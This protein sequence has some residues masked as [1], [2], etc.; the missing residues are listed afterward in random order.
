M[1]PQRPGTGVFLLESEGDFPVGWSTTE[2]TS[3]ALA[4]KVS[5]KLTSYNISWNGLDAHHQLAYHRLQRDRAGAKGPSYTCFRVWCSKPHL[6]RT[7][8]VL[9]PQAVKRSG[10][11]HINGTYVVDTAER[12][13]ARLRLQVQVV[14]DVAMASKLEEFAFVKSHLQEI[15]EDELETEEEKIKAARRSSCHSQLPALTLP[16]VDVSSPTLNFSESTVSS[17]AEHQMILPGPARNRNLNLP[18]VFHSLM[19]RV[20]VISTDLWSEDVPGLDL[21]LYKHQRRGLSWMMQRESGSLWD[22]VL[23]HPFSVPGHHHESDRTLEAEFSDPAYDVCGGMLCDE[24]GLGKTVTML[25]LILLTKGQS[26][27]N[28]TVRVNHQRPNSLSD[29]R[30]LPWNRFFQSNSFDDQPDGYSDQSIRGNVSTLLSINWLRIVVDEGHKLGHR[31]STQ[32]M[33]IS[34]LLRADK[35][36]ESTGTPSPNFRQATDLQYL[37]GLLVFLRNQPYGR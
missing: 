35:R 2:I 17:N 9:Y 33:Q 34:Q 18:D 3:D 29:R 12:N 27:R 25:A 14:N 10:V 4:N 30:H 26:T 24:P 20:D 5:S 19:A 13:V 22:T 8:A 37:H 15:G 21:R 1:A 31:V 32:L 11:L 36:L 23:L 6:G 28:M 16:R 7:E